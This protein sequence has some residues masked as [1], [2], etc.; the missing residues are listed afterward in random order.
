MQVALHSIY[1]L[2]YILTGCTVQPVGIWDKVVVYHLLMTVVHSLVLI[3]CV[4]H[5]VQLTILPMLILTLHVVRKLIYISN[6][7]HFL[8]N[9][10]NVAM[11]NIKLQR[12]QQDSRSGNYII[13]I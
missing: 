12:M 7:R 11:I 2:S 3:I 6:S 13:P 10:V 1:T 9:E 4:L 8:K 5:H